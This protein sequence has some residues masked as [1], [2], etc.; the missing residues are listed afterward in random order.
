[1]LL[2]AIIIFINIVGSWYIGDAN[3]RIVN[4]VV[5]SILMYIYSYSYF[6]CPVKLLHAQVMLLLAI[7]I[8][9]ACGWKNNIA[10]YAQLRVNFNCPDLCT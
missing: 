6:D 7:I 2:R 5:K 8:V 3:T 10:S 4:F 1:M 9:T